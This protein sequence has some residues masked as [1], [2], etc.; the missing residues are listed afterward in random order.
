LA[1]QQKLTQYI[2]DLGLSYKETAQ[3]FVFNCPLCNGKQKLYLRKK[4]GK[5]KCFKCASTHRFSG[6]A[7][8][9]LVELTDIPLV[10]I[11]NTLYG[12]AEEQSGYLDLQLKD[13]FGEDEEFP[14]DLEPEPELTELTWPYHCIPILHNG[15]IKG[16]QYLE[17]REVSSELADK[18]GI[19]YSPQNRAVVFP[20][21]V[22]N[23][24]Y[25][26]QYRTIDKNK[27]VINDRLVEGTKAW[28]S[29]NLPRD[30][31]FMF[32]DR[33]QNANKAIL[34]EG[35]V[36]CLKVDNLGLGNVCCMGK[37]VS[38]HH[39]TTVLRTGIKIV[40]AGL[41][42]DAWE[43]LDPLLTKFGDEVK[44]YRVVLPEKHGEKI[45][46]GSLTPDE[47]CKCVLE[48]EQM[49]YNKLYIWLKPFAF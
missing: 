11:K 27:Y 13:F 16:Q 10:T 37:M 39:V 9:A 34:T 46:L 6:Y 42:M 1:F 49:Q 31:V 15:A 18:Y 14:E 25:G 5:F 33:L 4:D 48:A 29:P 30:K 26:W 19:R 32:S 47:A 21:I 7:E 24:L 45:D 23:K 36:D 3:S 38:A 22:N 2:K 20:V 17:G 28:S 41:D 44:V 12:F 43:E 40:Y 35:P 8:Y